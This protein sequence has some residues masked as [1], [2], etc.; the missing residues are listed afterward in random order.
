MKLLIL[1]IVI[2]N[3]DF[4]AFSQETGTFTDPRDGKVYQTVVIGTQT[5]MAENLAFKTG[6]DCSAYNNDKDHVAKYGYLYN[7]EAAK[8][9][10]PEGWHLPSDEEWT[11]LTD[12]LGGN[13]VAGEKM[14]ATTDWEFDADGVATNECGFSTLPAG[15]CSGDGS[16]KHLGTNAYFWSSTLGATEEYAMGRR[17]YNYNSKVNRSDFYRTDGCSVRCIKNTP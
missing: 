14:K 9:A 2:L 12:Y 7:W 5:W 15:S 8:T 17:L 10:C 13:N 3:T 1:T 16:F 4:A 11:T 6:N